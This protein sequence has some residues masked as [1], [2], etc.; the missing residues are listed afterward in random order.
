MMDVDF[1]RKCYEEQSD[2]FDKTCNE[3]IERHDRIDSA[4]LQTAEDLKKLREQFEESQREQNVKDIEQAKE[5]RSNRWITIA[6]LLL[7]AVSTACAVLALILQ[8]L[9]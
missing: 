4:Q 3:M 7:S 1:V 5:N 9:G 8:I 6:S 2:P